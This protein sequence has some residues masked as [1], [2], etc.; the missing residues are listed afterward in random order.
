MGITGASGPILGYYLLKALREEKDVETF[1]VMSKGAEE[2]L[3]DESGITKS[4]IESLATHVYS[5][6][7]MNAPIASG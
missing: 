2:I 3:K 4:E 5:E 1:L 6:Y 7:E